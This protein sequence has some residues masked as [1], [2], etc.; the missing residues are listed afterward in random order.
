MKNI[1]IVEVEHRGHHFASYLK[2]IVKELQNKNINCYMVA[3]KIANYFS[4]DYS[5]S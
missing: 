5:F 1:L 3:N 2:S 4:H